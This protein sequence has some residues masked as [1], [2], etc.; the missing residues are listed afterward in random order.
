MI[1]PIIKSAPGPLILTGTNTFATSSGTACAK[2]TTTA[3]LDRLFKQ[4]IGPKTW[5]VVVKFTQTAAGTTGQANTDYIVSLPSG[6]TWDVTTTTGMPLY[7][8]SINAQILN[9]NN[10][11]LDSLVAARGWIRAST[12]PMFHV[13]GVVPYT[14]TTFR[15]CLIYYDFSNYPQW[16]TNYGYFNQT[17]LALTCEFIMKAA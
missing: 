9:T 15:I 4:Q 1:S 3:A 8:G 16:G 17:Q 11:G 5:R 14:A 6:L 10:A 13:V 12:Q 7:T 2:G